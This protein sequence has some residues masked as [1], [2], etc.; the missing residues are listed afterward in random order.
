MTKLPPLLFEG[1]NKLRFTGGEPTI[2]RQICNLIEFS[3]SISSIETI[4]IT[5]NGIKLAS[6]LDELHKAGLTHVNISLDTLEKHKFTKIT[7][8]E[9]GFFMRVISAI[10]KSMEKGLKVKVNCV[11]I[12]GVNDDE[13]AK[14]VDLTRDVPLDV[15][16]IELMPFD[17][18]DWSSRKLVSYIEIIQRL[19]DTGVYLV[20]ADKVKQSNQLPHVSFPI[21]QDIHDPHDTTKWYRVEGSSAGSGRVGFIT[22]MSSHFCGS[23]NRLRITADG[24]LKVCLFGDE[25]FSLIDAMRKHEF[26]NN[27]L[28][29]LINDVVKQKKAVLGGFME[30]PESLSQKKNRPMI[31]IGG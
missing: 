1:V 27:L 3:R 2:S 7:R 4:G 13:V 23:C 29:R 26:D 6:K 10:Y 5:T 19:K 9:D 18:N 22:S 25:S 28:I 15:R 21:I 30:T 8:R 14:F 12:R 16:F 24:K 11:V 20:K 31:L 17:Q